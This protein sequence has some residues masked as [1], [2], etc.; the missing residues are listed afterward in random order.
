MSFVKDDNACLTQLLLNL[1]KDT[2]VFLS[3]GLLQH[4]Y[5]NYFLIN[6]LILSINLHTLREVLK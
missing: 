5:I 3:F 1:G 6:Q 4:R 2:L